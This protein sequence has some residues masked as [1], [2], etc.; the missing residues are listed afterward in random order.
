MT[1]LIKEAKRLQKLAGISEIK[2]N[3]P[4]ILDRILKE[5]IQFSKNI[6]VEHYSNEELKFLEDISPATSVE[7]LAKKIQ[8]IDNCLTEMVGDYLGMFFEE[9]VLKFLIDDIFP[10]L[11][12]PQSIAKE[13]LNTLDELYERGKKN[14]YEKD[15]YDSYL[16]TL[17]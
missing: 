3:Q 16:K 6:S 1:Q 8:Y 10:K 4:S 14:G 15:S 13:L 5:Y 2:I 7:D 11:K 9:V 12:V 17:T